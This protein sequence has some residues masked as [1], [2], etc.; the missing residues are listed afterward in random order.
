[1]TDI[2]LVA[3]LGVLVVVIGFL[4][5]R[6]RVAKREMPQVTAERDIAL[7]LL[8]G[9]AVRGIAAAL[10]AIT[11]RYAARRVILIVAD[12]ATNHGV[13]A[14]VVDG[15][16]EP[17]AATDLDDAT[18]PAIDA[19]AEA[20]SV[21]L[22]V[23]EQDPRITRFAAAQGLNSALLLAVTGD[24]GRRGVL[25]IG[26]SSR[27]KPQGIGPALQIAA[28]L[29]TGL[30]A[31]ASL[32]LALA[33][34][35]DDH[36]AETSRALH[37]PLTNLPTRAIFL[38]ALQ[39][40]LDDRDGER[41]LGVVMVRLGGLLAAIERLG[42][43]AGAA[44]LGDVGAR[45]SRLMRR[46]DMAARVGESEFALLLLDL[47]DGAEAVAVAER[48]RIGLAQPVVVGD[49][50][51]DT[52][53]SIGIRV[54]G[55]QEVATVAPIMRDAAAATS[56][57][58]GSP[59]GYC[60]FNK[61][62][63]ADD[64]SVLLEDLRAALE[65]DE[66]QLHYQPIVN[67]SDGAVLGAEAL[68]RWQHPV[69]GAI[70]P[71]EFLPL[72][73]EAGLASQLGL[74]VL[75]TACS[76]LKEWQERYPR[77]PSLAISVNIAAEHLADDTFATDALRVLHDTEIDPE[78]VILEFAEDVLMA[79]IML[80]PARLDPL[81]RAGVHLAVDDVGTGHAT[82]EY[83]KRLP[84][85]ILKIGRPFIA[86]VADG[87]AATSTAHAIVQQG[88]KLRM[89]LVAEGVETALQ[90]SLLRSLGCVM[91]QGF[92]LSRPVDAAG[93]A[94]LLERG[95]VHVEAADDVR[96]GVAAPS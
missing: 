42:P 93:M 92:H 72:A 74:W 20:T 79:D 47:R 28:Y 5:W 84:V 87:D 86:A 25:A 40:G 58:Q 14:A 26:N 30:N 78:C 37:D 7:G 55:P 31:G 66:L 34:A 82:L 46:S 89:S 49:V 33:V 13:R 50:A 8:D 19:I 73:N 11:K 62:L 60:L 96:E 94:G 51:L 63:A 83:L 54:V 32:A 64:T 85:D 48:L 16:V 77:E 43:V 4:V 10:S 70:A 95:S 75:R 59:G 45:I 21:I 22:G 69:R 41:P 27:T 71:T 90:V 88:E 2:L 9:D 65:A 57:A 80:A 23:G 15:A 67:I 29:G 52:A 3:G 81:Q 68:V 1:M 53:A 6:L 91:A 18:V 35:V 17:L 24:G 44:V 12:P 76:Q 38:E 56:L 36:H 61:N 39:A